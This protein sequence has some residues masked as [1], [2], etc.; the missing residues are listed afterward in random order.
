MHVRGADPWVRSGIVSTP[1]HILQTHSKPDLSFP[2]LGSIIF[3]P[4]NILKDKILGLGCVGHAEPFFFFFLR[5]EPS[6]WLELSLLLC[7]YWFEYK[8]R[9]GS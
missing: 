5:T 6:L 8:S 1:N 4:S 2:Q 9:H 3:E 7:I